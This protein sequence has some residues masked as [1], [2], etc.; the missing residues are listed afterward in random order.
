MS[1]ANRDEVDRLIAA[2]KRERPDLDLAPLTI[3]SRITR[4]SRQLDIAR[5]DAFAELDTWGFDVLAALRRAGSPYQLSPGQLIQETM[6]TSGTI[7]NRLDGLEDLKLITRAPDPEDGRGSLV[8][9]TA[10]GVRAVDKAM[11]DLLDRER[12]LLASLTKDE[13]ADL[14]D[15]LSQL[16][17]T[18]EENS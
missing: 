1:A 13:R 11:E 4:I 6:V 17:S 10:A 16:A 2:W 14:A 18:L 7:T 5:R 15:L 9:L 12:G 3:L 8:K